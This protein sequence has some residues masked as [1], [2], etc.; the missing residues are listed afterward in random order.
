MSMLNPKRFLGGISNHSSSEALGGFPNPLLDPF[1]WITFWDDFNIQRSSDSTADA[2]FGWTFI[3]DVAGDYGL[4]ATVPSAFELQTAASDNDNIIMTP[5][6]ITGTSNP[7]IMSTGL[8]EDKDC[9]IACR[10]QHDEV[11]LRSFAIGLGIPVE[12]TTEDL[13]PKGFLIQ[14]LDAS[15]A[16]NVRMGDTSTI[17]VQ[18]V[19]TAVNDTYNDIVAYYR[20]SD[21]TLLVW[22]DNVLVAETNAAGAL[23]TAQDV[24]VMVGLMAGSAAVRTMLID[25]ML[26]AIE[27]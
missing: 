17:T 27:R 3:A 24:S 21:T 12:G 23:D 2:S 26:V 6:C 25:Y 16:I 9:I 13:T 20:A 15:A 14:G 5:A 19:A 10:V 18:A 4:S 1:R 11:L 7:A 8:Q 22:A